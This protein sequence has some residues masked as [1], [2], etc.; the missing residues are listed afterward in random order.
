MGLDET[1]G[2]CHESGFL[3]EVKMLES[4]NI[5]L[6]LGG[7]LGLPVD[8]RYGVLVLHGGSPSTHA[9]TMRAL[10][11]TSTPMRARCWS[12]QPICGALTTHTKDTGYR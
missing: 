7:Q 2:I 6:M 3:E 10:R 8:V 9:E 11:P 4:R 5:L 12:T 1:S